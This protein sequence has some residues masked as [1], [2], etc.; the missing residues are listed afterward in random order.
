M[1]ARA[2]GLAVVVVSST[3]VGEPKPP[4]IAGESAEAK[5]DRLVYLEAFGKFGLYGVGVER[6]YHRWLTLGSAFSFSRASE[7]TIIGSS[8][9]LGTGSAIR[10]KHR[11]F[12]QLG[13]LMSY[14]R[15]PSA[16]GFQG[17]T[18][19]GHGLHVTA[20]YEYR[21]DRWV[22]RGHAVMTAGRGGVAP[23][24]GSSVGVRF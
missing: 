4:T 6:R 17:L 2:I 20:G 16:P 12:A 8:L 14:E 7:R 15:E 10:G 21:G 19:I 9:Y 3:A 5:R 11:W 24:A 22:V 1:H 13:H 23:W 18:R